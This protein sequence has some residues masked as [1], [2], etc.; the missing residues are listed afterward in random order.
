MSNKFFF[1]SVL[2]EKSPVYLYSLVPSM[3]AVGASG[4]SAVCFHVHGTMDLLRRF[5]LLFHHT[6]NSWLWRLC[7]R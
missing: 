7:G 4:D 5:L 6:H 1:S 3:G 2:S